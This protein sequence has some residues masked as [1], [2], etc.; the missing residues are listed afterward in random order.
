[1]SEPANVSKVIEAERF[2][3]R[4]SAG[5]IR[6]ELG[7]TQHGAIGLHLYDDHG[8]V[9]AEL[10]VARDGASGLQLR[11]EAE[12]PRVILY[13]DTDRP[14]IATPGLSLNSRDGKGNIGLSV[15]PDGSSSVDF[16]GKE[17][18]SVGMI[19]SEAEGGSRLLRLWQDGKVVFAF[20]SKK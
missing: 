9:R 7:E 18:Q 19:F 2:V 10:V 11:D 1:M 15:G 17:K 4:D 14:D 20:P 6:A 8:K 16:R 12:F 5:R 3:L 13:L